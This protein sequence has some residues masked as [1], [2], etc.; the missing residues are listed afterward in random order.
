MKYQNRE[1][2]TKSVQIDKEQFKSIEKEMEEGSLTFSEWLHL[3]LK[4]TGTEYRR[5]APN[6]LLAFK[7]ALDQANESYLKLA[8]EVREIKKKSAPKYS[9]RNILETIEAI[10]ELSHENTQ[11]FSE[12]IGEFNSEITLIYKKIKD[13]KEVIQGNNNH[14]SEQIGDFDSE[15]TLIHDRLEELKKNISSK[16]VSHDYLKSRL[17]EHESDKSLE[18]L[19]DE[20]TEFCHSQIADLSRIKGRVQNLEE[21]MPHENPLPLV[22]ANK[23]AIKSLKEEVKNVKGDNILPMAEKNASAI[24]ILMKRFDSLPVKEESLKPLIDDNQSQIDENKTQISLVKKSMA[25]K[26]H[27]VKGLISSLSEKHNE[28]CKKIEF[29]HDS[30]NEISTKFEYKMKSILATIPKKVWYNPFTWGF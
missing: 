30:L 17:E 8:K 7:E 29:L 26:E 10:K 28:T 15:I 12:Q 6:K 11:H 1:F 19:S 14:F 16:F 21:E 23:D 3:K 4:N 5:E 18:T 20:F 9:E 22:E 27:N 13:L 24:E 25:A 2:V